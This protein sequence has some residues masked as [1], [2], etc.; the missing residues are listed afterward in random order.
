[1]TFQ[2]VPTA[3]E[4]SDDRRHDRQRLGADR[5]TGA[6]P[7]RIAHLDGSCGLPTRGSP[8]RRGRRGREGSSGSSSGRRRCDGWQQVAAVPVI[9]VRARRTSIIWRGAT[10]RHPAASGCTNCRFC[11]GTAERWP[12]IVF[13]RPGHEVSPLWLGWGLPGVSA[14]P[15]E[16]AT[17]MAQHDRPSY[18]LRRAQQGRRLL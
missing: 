16:P 9:T 18:G 2:P 11:Q 12:F 6:R 17:F 5:R 7:A 14:T 10:S 13:S 3:R 15:G 4:P 8:A 1:V